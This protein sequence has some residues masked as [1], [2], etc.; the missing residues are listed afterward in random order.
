MH[1]TLF[2]GAAQPA[3]KSGNGKRGLYRLA[4]GETEWQP[5]DG[6]LPENLKA[7]CIVASGGESR[8][9]YV[10]TQKGLFRSEDGGDSW[11]DLGLAMEESSV[12]SILVHPN[13]ADTIYAGLDH[14]A[15]AKTTDGGKSW[16]R[17]ATVQ[18]TGA[19][20]GCFPVRVLG[21]AADPADPEQ[22]YA[23]LEVGGL[24]RSLDGG[25]SWEDVSQ[26]LLDLSQQ[27]H[28]RNHILSDIDTEGMMDV[29]AVAVSASQP[30]TVWAANR[31]GLFTSGDGGTNWNEFGIKRFSDLSYGRDLIVS[32]HDPSVLYAALSTSARGDAG[33]LYCSR[34]MGETW[35]RFDR[36][37]SIDSTV[38]DV[39]VSNGDPDRVCGAARLGQVFA[40]ED[41]GATWE[42]LPLP[43]GVSDVRAVVSV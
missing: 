11:T 25:E 24:I 35:Q 27:P 33:S 9:L 41:G 32:P 3:P 1:S 43:D 40:T 38:M 17:L 8:T 15:I 28:L 13:D 5:L 2:A 36:G 39:N 14:T 30:S 42:M 10:G 7:T 19:I 23:A 20:T 16:R 34:D 29:H 37:I 22:I 31:M 6:G 18:P 4:P 26:G 12:Y 21:M